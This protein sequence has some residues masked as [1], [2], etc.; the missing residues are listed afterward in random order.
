MDS[1]RWDD[2]YRTSTE[3]WSGSPNPQLATEVASMDPGRALDCGCGE[4]ADALWLAETGWEVTGVDFS[5]VALGRATARANQR[6]VDVSGRLTFIQQD[7][8]TWRPPA[9]GFEL[10]SVQFVH[11]PTHQRDEMHRRLAEGVAPGGVL[12]LVG[13]HPLD[14]DL[15]IR[16]PARDNVFDGQEVL[17]ALAV[18]EAGSPWNIVTDEK[19][20]REGVD[21]G[22]NAVTL[23]DT[24]VTLRREQA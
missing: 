8:T 22:G 19:R 15:D 20:S 10:V 13:H 5:S 7:L 2:R 11:L 24:V 16:R 1:A 3:L 14:L 9:R 21:A 6:G 18:G 4:G 12:L 17:D 23:H